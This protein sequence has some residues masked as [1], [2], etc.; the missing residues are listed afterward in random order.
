MNQNGNDQAKLRDA[1][2][3][4]DAVVEAEADACPELIEYAKSKGIPVLAYPGEDYTSAY[5]EF[6]AAL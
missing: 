1:I 6:Y 3:N 4:S 5:K 2:D